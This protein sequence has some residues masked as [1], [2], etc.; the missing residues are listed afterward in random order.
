MN[1]H[2]R[3]WWI[4][5]D[6]AKPELKELARLC[7]HPDFSL[8]DVIKKQKF[9]NEE[10]SVS[11]KEAKCYLKSAR[12][13]ELPDEEVRKQ[14]IKLISAVKAIV[15]V[16]NKCEFQSIKF[17]GSGIL[18]EDGLPIKSVMFVTAGNVQAETTKV[19]VIIGG[20]VSQD[21]SYSYLNHLS[22]L[23]D[24]YPRVFDALYYFSQYTS[25]FSLYKVYET[26]TYDINNK[27]KNKAEARIIKDGWATESEIDS[28]GYSAQYS[29]ALGDVTDVTGLHGSRHSKAEYEKKYDE[30][31]PFTGSIM[32][33]PKAKK[34]IGS[35]LEN[36]LE[37]KRPQS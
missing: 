1:E 34:L 31:H 21:D 26:I 9:G 10:Q 19:T 16:K 18:T 11:T 7:S 23:I 5:L 25:W 30:E 36:W 6:G 33:L 2:K 15:K 4:E 22:D 13:A 8:C 27:S 35:L 3:E 24:D 29:D 14:A 17:G 12:L 20:K 32:N 37:S 28:F